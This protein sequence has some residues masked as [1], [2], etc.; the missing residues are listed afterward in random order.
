MSDG[1]R[2]KSNFGD[3]NSFNSFRHISVTSDFK[4]STRF[5]FGNNFPR[6]KIPI[7]E[8]RD[9]TRIKNL[10]LSQ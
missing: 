9:G 7:E 8:K 5:D 4:E 2:E 10:L 1:E 3:S 6:I